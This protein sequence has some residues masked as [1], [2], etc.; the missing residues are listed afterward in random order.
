M[1]FSNPD[2]ECACNDCEQRRD[3]LCD[4]PYGYRPVAER[5]RTQEEEEKF[6]SLIEEQIEK[7]IQIATNMKIRIFNN[8]KGFCK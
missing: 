2:L 8:K 7:A 3:N 1:H 5:V 6:K 4:W